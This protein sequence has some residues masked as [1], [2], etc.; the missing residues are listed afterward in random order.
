MENVSKTKNSQTLVSTTYTITAGDVTDLMKNLMSLGAD[1][2]QEQLA[3]VVNGRELKEICAV[4]NLGESISGSAERAVAAALNVLL[5]PEKAD[6]YSADDDYAGCI[7]WFTS[8]HGDKDKMAKDLAPHKKEIFAAWKYS[9]NVST[10]YKRVRKYGAELAYT[11]LYTLEERDQ[12]RAELIAETSETGET[13]ETGGK[14]S[15]NRD[16]YERGVVEQGTL[17]RAWTSATND[18]I[19]KKHPKSERIQASLVHLTKALQE[20]GAPLDDEEL[21]DFMKKVAKR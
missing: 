14:P 13:G 6:Q 19:I 4:S 1:A 8:E 2:T 9:S 7:G 3:E 5:P 21:A 18:D 10:K 11:D 17:Y 15:R 16:L 12:H 20:L